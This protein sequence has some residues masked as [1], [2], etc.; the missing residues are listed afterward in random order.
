MLT[1]A[2]TSK[3]TGIKAHSI[4]RLCLEGRIKFVKIGTKYL[5]NFDRFIDFLNGGNADDA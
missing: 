3:Q 4:R 1:I 2:E 5:I